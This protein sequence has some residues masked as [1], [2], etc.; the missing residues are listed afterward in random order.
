MKRLVLIILLLAFCTQCT[1]G[2]SPSM[3][4]GVKQTDTSSTFAQ[5][6]KK[7]SLYPQGGSEAQKAYIDPNT[8]QLVSPPEHDASAVN[9]PIEAAS[10]MKLVLSDTN[11]I[12][13]S[14][15]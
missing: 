2:V 4:D 6:S 10:L 5:K 13:V 14:I 7:M 9:K 1:Q 8:G 11:W 12:G 15:S 3:A